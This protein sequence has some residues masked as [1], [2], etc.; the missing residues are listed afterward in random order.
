MD[1]TKNQKKCFSK[2]HEARS[3]IVSRD[4]LCKYIWNDEP[5]RSNLAQLS[6]LTKSLRQKLMSKGF[7]SDIIQTV[8]GKGY[9]LNKEFYTAY[10]EPF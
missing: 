3:T 9:Y 5:T 6:V 1:F 4:E 7:S 8:W 10:S 2:L